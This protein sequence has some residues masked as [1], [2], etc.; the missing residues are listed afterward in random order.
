MSQSAESLRILAIE[1]SGAAGSVAIAVG[2]SLVS[3]ADL[4]GQRRSTQLLA[5]T[6]HSLLAAAGWKPADLQ[7]IAVTI[8]PGSFTGLR[9]GVATAKMLAY[10]TGAAVLGIDTLRTIAAQTAAPVDEV[11]SLLDAGRG[12][13]LA[14][15]FR[16]DTA[17]LPKAV[18]ETALVRV[19]DWLA[20]LESMATTPGADATHLTGPAVR[21]LS[22]RLPPD[23]SLEAEANWEPRAATVARLAW[24]DYCAGRRDDAWT[25][26]PIYYRRSAAEEVWEK[27]QR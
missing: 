18:A 14:G 26:A 4:P 23:C 16:F 2:A 7:L 12:E 19:E 9:L 11:Q 6:I 13:V 17:G 1:T 8:G 15:H 27:K 10:V 22:G 21:A 25:L 24:H 3:L 20:R 5:P